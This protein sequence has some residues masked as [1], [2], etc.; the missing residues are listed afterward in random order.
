MVWGAGL[1]RTAN[2]EY[3][4]NLPI[5]MNGRYICLT[6]NKS[7]GVDVAQDIFTWL[8]QDTTNTTIK[9]YKKTNG[10]GYFSYLILGK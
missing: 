8:D 1:K 9:F 6:S 7:Q 2:E 4:V 3:P 10:E 5:T